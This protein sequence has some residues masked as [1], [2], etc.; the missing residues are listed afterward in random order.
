M[1]GSTIQVNYVTEWWPLLLIGFALLALAITALCVLCSMRNARAPLA[2]LV[3]ALAGLQT[4]QVASI[5]L[6]CFAVALWL[7]VGVL[8]RPR[9]R[10]RTGWPLVVLACAALL[11]STALTG[12]M[13][14]SRLVAIQLMLL[15][16][17]CACLIAFGGPEDV[18]PFMIG[19]LVVTSLACVAAV[20]Q[21]AGVLPYKIYLGTRRPIGFY[22]EPD[23]L[24]MFSA[25]GLVVAFRTK[26]GWLRTPLVFLHVVVLLLAAA[27]AAW[28]AVVVLA[29]LGWVI[30]KVTNGSG[31]SKAEPLRGGFRMAVGA[32]LVVVV[33]LTVSPDLRDSLQSRIA[34]VS[35][36]RTE[37]GAMARQQQNT[38]LL[39]LNSLAP[40]TGLGLSASGRVGVSGRIA[41]IGTSKNNIASNWIL[42]WWVDGGV[43]AIPLILLFMG[44]AVRR[45][46]VTTGFVLGTVLVS[47]L[48]SNAML[49]PISWLALALCLMRTAPDDPDPPPEPEP[50]P[51]VDRTEVS[52]PAEM[53]IAPAA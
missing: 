45:L 17:T 51:G 27:R 36:G 37:V 7:L 13:V 4:A 33:A 2:V 41:Y 29:I 26:V 49:I 21:Y 5:H 38:S 9:D 22:S 11:A 46:T 32:A 1:D 53:A 40:V 8:R 30:T 14:N 44:A 20:A 25:V 15:A 23:W 35:G 31:R 34:G 10:M 16:G 19:L 50:E 3:G 18:R 48:F 52:E 24:G 43:L 28:L 12:E 42:G 47:S 39:E 6:F